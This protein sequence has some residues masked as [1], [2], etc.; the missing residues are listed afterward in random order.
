LKITTKFWIGLAILVILS[1]LGLLLPGYFK[2]DGAWGEWGV[3][4]IRKLIGYVP[5]GLNKLSQF[6]N[7]PMPDYAFKGWENKSL[8][9]LS[10][11]YVVSAIIGVL[12]II[13]A[14]F[15]IGKFL[16]KNKNL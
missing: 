2:A 7:S 1:P 8:V 15:L 5:Q 13:C 6:W 16:S 10:I 11:S 3:D 12:V 4:E 9:H 14:V